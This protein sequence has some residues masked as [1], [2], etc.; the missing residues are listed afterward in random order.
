MLSLIA[1]THEGSPVR[2][3][4]VII[5]LILLVLIAAPAGAVVV[6]D[7]Y[8]ALVPVQDHSAEQLGRATSAGL[9]QVLVK[10]SGSRAVLEDPAI[11]EVLPRARNYLQQY[12]YRRRD[13]DTLEL[14]IQFDAEQVTGILSRAL[15]PL[16]TADRPPVL[17]W[18]VV[19]DESGRRV[20]SRESFPELVVAVEAEFDRRGVPVVF[21]L[22]DLQDAVAVDVH[23]LW[24][25]ESLSIYRASRRY[26]REDVLVG[27][28]Q[29]ISGQRWMGDWMYLWRDES[30]SITQYGKDLDGFVAAGVQLTAEAMA[31]RYAVAPTGTTGAGIF[32]RVDGL[33]TFAD[34]RASANH[35]EEVEL[36]ES[37]VVAYAGNGTVVFRVNAQLEAD[38]LQRVISA[39]GKLSLQQRF[40]PLAPELPTAELVYLWNP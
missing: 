20:A 28:L 15:L 1:N 39:K 24:Q 38:Q 26:Q 32:V 23:D 7:L 35:L 10:A 6:A 17:V 37:A 16:W 14:E 18:L 31:A 13:R 8:R 30:K 34:Y 11:Q 21:P 29:A 22:H 9:A 40:Q 2:P 25:L 36:V 4:P 5:S 19:D 3:Q 27:R 33:Q 12:Q